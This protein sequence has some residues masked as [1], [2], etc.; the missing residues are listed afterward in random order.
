M[1]VVPCHL[2]L[3]SG[4]QTKRVAIAVSRLEGGRCG[5]RGFRSAKGRGGQG[6]FI[7]RV[8]ACATCGR[9]LVPRAKPAVRHNVTEA[10][11]IP[12]RLISR[13]C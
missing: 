11:S 13:P 7:R 1:S 9:N 10:S 12:G 5:P 8:E 6:V 4:R 2:L 3:E